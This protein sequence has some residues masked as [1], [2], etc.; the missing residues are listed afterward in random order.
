MTD[1]PTADRARE[2][3]QQ[4]DDLHRAVDTAARALRDS[5]TARTAAQRVL[6]EES[7]AYE[8]ARGDLRATRDRLASLGAPQLADGSITVGWE[9]LLGW[10]AER[11]AQCVADLATVTAG[12]DEL[13]AERRATLDA[14][15]A[16]LAGLDVRIDGEQ[17]FARRATSSVAEVLADAVAQHRTLRDRRAS[18][19]RLTSER[20]LTQ[21]NQVV[22]STLGNLLRSNNFPGWLEE[23]ALDVLVLEASENLAELSNGQFELT[24]QRGEFFVVDH[25][26]ADSRRSV[27]TLSGGE[28]FQSSLALALALSSQLATLAYQGAAQLDSIFL[29]EGF[30]TLD[31]TTLEV[32]AETLEN[33]A[34]GERMVGIIT[35]VAALADRVPT[36]F[37]VWRRSFGTRAAAGRV[38]AA[39]GA[40]RRFTVDSWDPAYGASLDPE[41][42]ESRATVDVSVEQLADGWLPVRAP[43]S[44]AD[45]A[46]DSGVGRPDAV[47]FVDGVRRVEAR[48]WIE[49]GPPTGGRDTAR[50]P[51]PEVV[52]SEAALGLCAS[53]AAGVLCCCGLGSHLLTAQVRRRLVTFASDAVD[54]STAAGRFEAPRRMR[55]QRRI[56]WRC[57]RTRC[58]GGSASSN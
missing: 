5:R 29:D 11:R 8:R 21:Q 22:A 53:Y 28:T 37:V 44:V 12:I 33:L 14:L 34:R 38:T 13:A 15:R 31:E 48:A 51:D 9:A 52:P 30:G 19:D 35:H 55:I 41:L 46:S 10:C 57:C 54:I 50:P 26:D 43:R 47:L 36:R 6:D 2:L 3:V 42:A 27:R 24:H 1:A 40:S 58:S 17:D 23:T 56:R 16:D 7:L 20:R 39:A 49:S 45:G 25:A 32:V 4:L 18:A